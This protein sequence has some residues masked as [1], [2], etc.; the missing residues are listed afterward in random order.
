MKNLK[1]VY[2]F[3]LVLPLVF[4]VGCVGTDDY[5]D[6]LSNEYTQQSTVF[7]ETGDASE[8]TRL[9]PGNAPQTIEVG[10]NNA[11][12][13]DLTVSFNVTKDGAA[14]SE[15]VDYSMPDAVISSSEYFGSTEITFFAP[16]KYEVTVGNASEGSLVVVDNKAIFNVPPA[17]TVSIS[18]GD[19]FYDYDLYHVSGN[20]DLNGD[21][22]ASTFDVIAFETFDIYPP[23]GFSSIYIQDFWG[24]NAGTEVVMTVEVDGVIDVYDVIMDISK[25]VLVIETTVDE[26]GNPVYDITAL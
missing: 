26:E 3:L 1:Y 14:A 22:L 24:D 8:I 9:A 19:A 20:Q 15:G 13:A 5:E 4:M 12:G 6:V 2:K 25:F 7:I 16:G 17:V 23:V 18:W 21:V 10:I 11:Q